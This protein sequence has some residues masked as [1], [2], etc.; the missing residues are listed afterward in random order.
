MFGYYEW[1]PRSFTYTRLIHRLKSTHKFSH[2]IQ[3]V[4]ASQAFLDADIHLLGT[5]MVGARMH[6]R[7][8]LKSL[9]TLTKHCFA[10]PSQYHASQ[11]KSLAFICDRGQT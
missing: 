10:V 5:S 7:I 6:L 4:T 11:T 2:D 9:P 8:H 3:K 1:F